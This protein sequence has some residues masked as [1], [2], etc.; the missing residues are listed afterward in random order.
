MLLKIP[1]EVWAQILDMV[2]G[3]DVCSKW[4]TYGYGWLFRPPCPDLSIFNR[5][6]LHW[7]SQHIFYKRNPNRIRMCGERLDDLDDDDTRHDSVEESGY[8]STGYETPP[9]ERDP[10]DG[11]EYDS[12]EDWG[13][14]AEGD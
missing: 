9:W 12:T 13:L 5:F 4:L 11:Y 1:N 3:A 14:S 8:D 10:D 2:V 6:G 7:V